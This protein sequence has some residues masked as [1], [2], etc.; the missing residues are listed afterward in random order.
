MATFS[1]KHTSG[2]SSSKQEGQPPDRP[3]FKGEL[4]N[5][6]TSGTAVI[7]QKINE[8]FTSKI[9]TG[10]TA[11][12]NRFTNLA[13]NTFFN[14]RAHQPR[15][16]SLERPRTDS[17]PLYQST[18]DMPSAVASSIEVPLLPTPTSPEIA[19]PPNF[20]SSPDISPTQPSSPHRSITVSDFTVTV[21]SNID[22]LLSPSPLEDSTSGFESERD[23]LPPLASSF[24]SS[25]F[26]PAK[27]SAGTTAVS[28]GNGSSPPKSGKKKKFSW[29][30]VSSSCEPSLL[31]LLINYYVVGSCCP[32]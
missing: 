12:K 26:S 20:I 23:Q 7:K 5:K 4:A 22:D 10:T 11:I 3:S 21:Q 9:T 29:H 24:R 32:T 15:P 8:E 2:D 28:S 27:S 1:P 19:M 16:I 17:D 14:G 18:L 30:N 6:I 13:M 31:S 25:A